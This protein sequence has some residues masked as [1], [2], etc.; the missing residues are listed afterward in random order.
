M[1]VG[2]ALLSAL[3]S[4]ADAAHLPKIVDSVGC[5]RLVVRKPGVWEPLNHTAYGI[6]PSAERWRE[7]LA[8]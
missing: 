1:H 4:V 7:E 3:P 8:E 2:E 5:L 6:E